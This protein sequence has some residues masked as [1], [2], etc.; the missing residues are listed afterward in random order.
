MAFRYN[1]QTTGYQ[2][3][4]KSNT[5]TIGI[6]GAGLIGKTLA[7]KLSKHGH[8]VQIANSRGPQTLQAFSQETG[9]RAVTTAEVVN[10]VALII[11]TIP[12]GHIRAEGY[13]QPSPG[14]GHYRGNDELLPASGWPD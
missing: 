6:I 7:R 8:Q 5:M 9:V 12:L 3:I 13:V 4:S 14:G 10:G 2:L 11:I 1:N